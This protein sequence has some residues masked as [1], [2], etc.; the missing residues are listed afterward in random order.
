MFFY[1][2]A[3]IN[4]NELTFS[5]NKFSVDDGVIHIGGLTKDNSGDRVVHTCIPDAIKIYGKKVCA[6]T[7]F[8]TS[9]IFASQHRRSANCAEMKRFARGH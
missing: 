4:R 7:C 1:Q 8:Q 5:H 2:L 9:N 3:F 6:F